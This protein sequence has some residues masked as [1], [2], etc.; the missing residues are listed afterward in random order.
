MPWYT[1]LTKCILS[2]IRCGNT[3]LRI[4]KNIRDLVELVNLDR[5]LYFHVCRAVIYFLLLWSKFANLT[6]LGIV[7]VLKS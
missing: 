4:L 5:L 2:G 3:F 6:N 7:E 1:A